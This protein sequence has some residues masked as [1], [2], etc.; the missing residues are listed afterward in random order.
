MSPRTRLWFILAISRILVVDKLTPV[1]TIL[2]P[3][4]VARRIILRGLMETLNSVAQTAPLMAPV[5][6][7]SFIAVVFRGL[8]LMT[9]M[10]WLH[11]VNVLVTP[12]E[13]A[14]P[15]ML[16]PRPYTVT[17]CVGLRRRSGLG[18]GKAL[19][20]CL[21]KLAG[22]SLIPL[23]LGPVGGVMIHAF[24][25]GSAFRWNMSLPLWALC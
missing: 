5:P 11:R 16:F 25:T 22:T 1:G 18:V 17:I 13:S 23:I 24:A 2:T 12:T 10:W 21:S 8:K 7:F 20:L 19:H 9:S 4:N 6:M 14:A 15:F 3:L